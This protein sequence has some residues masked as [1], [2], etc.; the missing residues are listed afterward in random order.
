M[1]DNEIKA[2][3]FVFGLLILRFIKYVTILSYWYIIK[4]W[5]YDISPS[6]ISLHQWEIFLFTS[7]YIICI[8]FY[9]VCY[10]LFWRSYYEQ[11]MIHSIVQKSHKTCSIIFLLY[12][13]FLFL[14]LFCTLLVHTINPFIARVV[15]FSIMFQP[16]TI[17][18]STFIYI[19][20]FSYARNYRY[21]PARPLGTRTGII[22]YYGW[23]HPY[24]S[25]SCDRAVSH[26]SHQPQ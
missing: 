2:H 3:T 5:L 7:F 15:W 25:R 19:Y 22:I 6:Q 16:R 11:S 21:H 9:V 26:T 10:G 8:L 23:T 1:R 18:F 24:T 4:I 14:W 20:I 12:F 17:L 13:V